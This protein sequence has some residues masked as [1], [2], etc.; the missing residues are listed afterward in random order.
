M[1]MDKEVNDSLTS[2]DATWFLLNLCYCLLNG[3]R[4]QKDGF[5]YPQKGSRIQKLKG[6]QT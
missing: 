6:R 2:L 1:K 3:D 4:M 5:V